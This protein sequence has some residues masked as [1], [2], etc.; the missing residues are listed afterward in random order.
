M[1]CGPF[2]MIRSVFDSPAAAGAGPFGLSSLQRET[3]IELGS[4]GSGGNFNQTA[5]SELFG[6]AL[7]EVRSADRRLAL[8]NAGRQVYLDLLVALGPRS[9]APCAT[10]AASP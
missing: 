9:L 3:I 7:V 2:H 5:L 6:L 10:S 8:T 4:R 1:E